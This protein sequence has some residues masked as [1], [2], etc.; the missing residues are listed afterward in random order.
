MY[1]ARK[2]RVTVWASPCAKRFWSYVTESSQPCCERARSSSLFHLWENFGLK[3]PKLTQFVSDR[4]WN[5]SM[6]PWSIDLLLPAS[7][8]VPSRKQTQSTQAVATLCNRGVDSLSPCFEFHTS[9]A[10]LKVINRSPTQLTLSLHPEKS[11]HGATCSSAV[12]SCIGGCQVVTTYNG[13]EK[14]SRVGEWRVISAGR[15]LEVGTLISIVWSEKNSDEGA[16]E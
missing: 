10:F 14:Q 9:S 5:G 2:R 1:V 12:F 13:E 15:G 7:L 11:H 4:V 6:A 16:F 8:L 3:L